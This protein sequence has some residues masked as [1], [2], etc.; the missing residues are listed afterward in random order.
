VGGAL[1]YLSGWSF[2]Q[3]MMNGKN[4]E[5]KTDLQCNQFCCRYFPSLPCSFLYRGVE[6]GRLEMAT[7][8]SAGPVI[9]GLLPFIE[10]LDTFEIHSAQ[11]RLQRHLNFGSK[12]G[13]TNSF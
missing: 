4:L 3:P 13:I 9:F 1:T 12:R 5:A 8:F 10:S 2:N 11:L 6:S 7:L